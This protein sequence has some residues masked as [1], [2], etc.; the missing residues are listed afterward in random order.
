MLSKAPFDFI[1]TT[2]DLDFSETQIGKLQRERVRKLVN[3]FLKQNS[4]LQIL[5]LNCGTGADAK[6]MATFNYTVIAT[7]AS[8]KMIDLA[9]QQNENKE[10]PMFLQ[11]TFNQLQTDSFAKK[12]DI[13]FSNFT[14]LNCANKTELVQLNYQLKQM[15]NSNGR[16]YFVLIGKYSWLEKLFFFMKGDKTKMNRRLRMDEI[17]LAPGVF[18]KTGCYSSREIA[19]IFSHFKLVKQKP[20]GLFIPTSYLESLLKKNKLIL[21]IVKFLEKAFGNISF[22]AN[23]G[24][25][26]FIEL[27]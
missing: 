11:M 22:L 7:D 18:V 1:A 16:L 20:I 12:F 10:N 15:L 6:W 13:V 4:H 14:G 24:D 21:P 17:Q 26:I 19:Q 27:R 9:K 3:P 8:A 23:Y 25:H 2:Y 5:E